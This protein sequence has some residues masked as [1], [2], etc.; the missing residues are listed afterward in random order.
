MTSDLAVRNQKFATIAEAA[1]LL[2]RP[3]SAAK[4]PGLKILPANPRAPI[5]YF[6]IPPNPMI[7]KMR[8][9]GEIPSTDRDSRF[10]ENSYPIQ[11]YLTVEDHLSTN[12]P[13]I[14]SGSIAM[15]TPR[16]RARTSPSSF[17]ISAM[18][19]C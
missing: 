4:P 16:P 6:E 1:I 10:R 19:M 17:M 15:N 7:P 5:D 3:T 13:N 14:F 12:L 11:S 9:A 2:I 8:A 18:L